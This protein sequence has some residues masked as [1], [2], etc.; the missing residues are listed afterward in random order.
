MS[1]TPFADMA[2]RYAELGLTIL[3][4]CP[5]NH[6]GCGPTHTK[7]CRKPGKAPLV[8]W[9][10]IQEVGA[11][12][13]AVARWARRWPGANI[14]M[15]TGTPSGLIVLDVDSEEGAEHIRPF[16]LPE[17]PTVRTHRGLRYHFAAP[18]TP[19]RK[20]DGLLPGVDL[21]ADGAC[22]VLPPSRH[23]SGIV[24]QWAVPL[25]A[26]LAPCPEWLVELALTPLRKAREDP[27]V[28]VTRWQGVPEGQRDDVA[29]RLAGRLLRLGLPGEEVQEILL[30]WVLRNAP[31]SHPWGEADIA[32]VVASIASREAQATLL[33]AQD[34]SLYGN[35]WVHRLR[36]S[37]V[38]HYEATRVIEKRRGYAP[39]ARLY[40]AHR[41]YA[42]VSGYGL[43]SVGGALRRLSRAGLI[44]YRPGKAGAASEEAS[45]VQR[46]LPMPL[47]VLS[48]RVAPTP[49]VYLCVQSTQGMN[50]ED[51]GS[52]LCSVYA[53]RD[54]LLTGRE[55]GEGDGDEE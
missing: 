19:L 48:T 38:G 35:T 46:V 25:T 51:P 24:Y 16:P 37:D 44:R 6:S 40:V 8:A 15:L 32:R 17:T 22:G 53:F 33:R 18:P 36:K 2:L 42:E 20:R 49:L 31:G 29:T 28:W 52:S 1:E 39:G 34:C 30:G 54:R 21:Q 4:L 10:R 27:G 55:R 23:V 45:E 7:R 26:G 14:G 50:R 9:S 5:P 13:E 12:P 41:E 43:G 3:P 11:S 47:P